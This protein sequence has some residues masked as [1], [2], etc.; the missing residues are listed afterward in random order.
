MFLKPTTPQVGKR[1]L[2]LKPPRFLRVSVVHNATLRL[3][4][5]GFVCVRELSKK[6]EVLHE[7]LKIDVGRAL[8]S[9]AGTWG[10]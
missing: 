5:A 7:D 3:N 10:R 1:N 9:E 8:P 6:V 2:A 4:P